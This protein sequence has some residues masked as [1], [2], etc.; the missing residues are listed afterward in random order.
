MHD[1]L[2]ISDRQAGHS[3]RPGLAFT[4]MAIAI[5]W[6]VIMG[7]D[8]ILAGTWQVSPEDYGVF[9]LLLPLLGLAPMVLRL[10]QP[11]II[12]DDREAYKTFI[13][14]TVAN[15]IM[16]AVIAILQ[17]LPNS[18]TAGATPGSYFGFLVGRTMGLVT[19]L[20]LPLIAEWIVRLFHYRVRGIFS[21]LARLYV[22]LLAGLLLLGELL[23]FRM[24]EQTLESNIVAAAIGGGLL[25]LG[26]ALSIRSGWLMNL[27]KR[28]KLALLG[29]SFLGFP[30]AT[31]MHLML[32]DDS[33]RGAIFSLMPALAPFSTVILLTLLFVH[34]VIF[35]SA[36]LA[37]PTADAID[38]RND[39]VTSLAN[40]ARLL[41]KSLETE[42]LVETAIALTCDATAA[43]AAWIGI[44]EEEGET[45]HY[46][47]TPKL[48]AHVAERLM[49]AR[50]P[51][52][53]TVAAQALS[54][55]RT[56]VAERVG[57]TAWEENGTRRELRS[58]AAVP[59]LLGEELL[60]TLY[61]AKER[62]DGFDREEIVVLNALADQ[63]AV[64][65]VHSRLIHASMERKRLEQEMMIARDL[66]Q[67]LLPKV[68]PER[69]CY[70]IHAESQPASI[71]G[72]DYYDVVRFSDNT[73]ALVI[74][75][76]AGKG[77]SAALYMGMVKGIVQA[78]SG[79]CNSPGEL[80][81]RSNVA[82]H[83][84]IDQRWFATMTCAQIIEESRALRISRAGHCPTLLVRNGKAAFSRP[85][86][87]GLAIAGPELFDA[88]LSVE[89]I[90][91]H[92]GDYAIFF[93]DGLP[94]A[95]SID[96]SEFGFEALLDVAAEAAARGVDAHGM[97]DAIV[98]AIERFA[99]GEPPT[100]DS[101][102]VV[103][104]WR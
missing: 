44:R 41:T 100:D 99:Q 38:R 29:L 28:Q 85:N 61:A 60:G 54:S 53:A 3:S 9:R 72:G 86:G 51:R 78:L 70:E 79:R 57:D 71:V 77:A 35:I 73:L 17:L 101:T 22:I 52:G 12:T 91:F 66:Q 75:D 97:R 18:Y 7:Y 37:L 11:D 59:L 82:L 31:V 45:M 50:M 55:R 83:G 67:R 25:A 21:I 104:R 30:A 27:R 24:N 20:G 10:L 16:A 56:E 6:L 93:S 74:A 5:T 62:D 8:A 19:M 88:N 49:K 89:E 48:P 96:G 40:F 80:L 102:L 76:V 14:L 13:R 26:L 46:G 47:D 68:M 39:E 58:V 65:L 87:L 103:L 42:D 98:E 90:A 69:P 92:E 15:F 2:D 32:R 33:A 23:P 43:S 95:R 63:I 4:L 81:A 34:M 64:A 94:E 84:A 1:Q 36:L